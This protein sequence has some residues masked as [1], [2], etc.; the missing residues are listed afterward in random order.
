[1]NDHFELQTQYPEPKDYGGG[2]L[3]IDSC[4]EATFWYQERSVRMKRV[5]IGEANEHGIILCGTE[6]APG[7]KYIFQ[8]WYLRYIRPSADGAKHGA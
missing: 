1:M 2:R 8:Q 4:G 5:N 7:G 6:L 3:R